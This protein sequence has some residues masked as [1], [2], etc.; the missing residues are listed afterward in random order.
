MTYTLID[1]VPASVTR[2]QGKAALIQAGLWGDVLTYVDGIA[3]PVDKAIAEVALY[4]TLHWDRSSP[5]LNAAA[6][7][8]GLDNEDLDDLFITAN[9][10]QL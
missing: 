9:N 2:A 3:D 7:E 1:Y 10:I 4:D 6:S 5:F 8:L